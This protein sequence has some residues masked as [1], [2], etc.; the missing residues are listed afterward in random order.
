[1]CGT[2]DEA[3]LQSGILVY[4]Q[5]RRKRLIKTDG[6]DFGESKIELHKQESRKKEKKGWGKK[7]RGFIFFIIGLTSIG[8]FV[9]AFISRQGKLPGLPRL[10][11]ETVGLSDTVILTKNQ[12]P[13]NIQRRDNET[14]KKF[15]DAVSALSGVYAFTVVDL[16]SGD[17]YGLNEFETMEAASIIKLPV[18]TLLLKQADEGK[19][20]LDS[21]YVLKD[22]DKI[23]GSGTLQGSPEGTIL[24]Y[25]KMLEYMGQVSDNTAFN[26]V[27]KYFGDDVI[28]DF[29]KSVGM[30]KTDISTNM[31]SPSDM[32]LLLEKIYE[33]RILSVKSRDLLFTDLTKTIYEQHLVKGVPEDIQVA[34]KYGREVHVVNDAG[35]V[36][37]ENPYVVVIMTG[38]IVEKEADNMFPALSKI[39][40]DG[41][42]Q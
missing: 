19:I 38:G 9:L 26:I 4:M 6:D 36:Y 35:V 2:T 12:I 1:M 24:T 10:S 7:E 3:N 25:R 32:A 34:H 22:S 28:N 27:R 23:G 8:A 39:I 33:G 17:T 20:N 13:V 16:K 31:T 40:Y 37:S 14:I 21:T 42:T 41:Q 18:M 29:A 15:S 30:T 5:F 11:S